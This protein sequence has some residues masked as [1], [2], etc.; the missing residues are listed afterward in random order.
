MQTDIKVSEN[1]ISDL[2]MRTDILL[3]TIEDLLKEKRKVDKLNKELEDFI[4]GENMDDEQKIKRHKDEE[5]KMRIKQEKDVVNLRL[6]YD[7]LES[8][9]GDEE[10]R[11][12]TKLDEKLKKTEDLE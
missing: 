3:S 7:L 4:S 5:R 8:T 1:K 12:K 9:H 10:G 2:Q 6:K 11:S